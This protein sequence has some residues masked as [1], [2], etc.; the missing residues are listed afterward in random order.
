M[1]LSPG[2]PQYE[3]RISYVSP[4]QLKPLVDEF[5]IVIEPHDRKSL[6]VREAA[7]DPLIW[8]V[9]LWG[10]PRDRALIRRLQTYPS[11]SRPGQGFKVLSRQGVIFG[12]R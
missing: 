9:L 12:D 8:S 7:E 10:S 1:I 11:L 6:T 5:T 3:D 2:K 4:K